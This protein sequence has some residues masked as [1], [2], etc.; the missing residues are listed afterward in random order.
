MNTTD[1]IDIVISPDNKPTEELTQKFA[2]ILSRELYYTRALLAS[3]I[4]KII[5]QLTDL[6]KVEVMLHQIEALGIVSF[7]IRDDVLQKPLRIFKANTLE[8]AENYIV[9]KDKNSQLFRLEEKN[10]CLVLKG[11]LRKDEEK[12][13]IS[14]IKNLNITA[15]LMTGGIPIG[16]TVMQ[17]TKEITSQNESFLRLFEK[18]SLDFCLEIKQHSFNYS[19]LGSDMS[20]SSL[21]NINL[22]TKRIKELF[23]EAVFD[24]KMGEF[25]FINTS[26]N[27]MYQNVD[28]E[29]K[30]IYL[31]Y[32]II[33]S[34]PK[35]VKWYEKMVINSLTEKL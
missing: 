9:F 12:E 11:I 21:C 4:P 2:T 17:K 18:N 32:Q 14:N 6:Q 30:L 20:T 10:V 28:I 29:C 23:H 3:K 15:T 27:S 35:F 19:C 13:V 24:D 34:H 1:L 33:K 22:I 25:P 8:F 31:Y 5:S 7:S 16:R 26:R